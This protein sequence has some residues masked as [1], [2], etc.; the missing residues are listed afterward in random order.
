MASQYYRV[1][2]LQPGSTLTH[3]KRAYKALAKKHHPDKRRNAD[4]P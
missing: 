1:L 2:G 3:I 4:L